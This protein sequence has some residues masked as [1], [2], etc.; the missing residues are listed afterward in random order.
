MLFVNTII[1]FLVKN[2]LLKNINF[3]HKRNLTGY[4][5]G[6]ER[7]VFKQHLLKNKASKLKRLYIH[8]ADSNVIKETKNL[9]N[10]KSDDTMRKIRSEAVTFFDRHKDDFIDILLMQR[11]HPEY[12]QEVSSPLSVKLYSREQVHLAETQKISNE[13]PILYFDATGSIVRSPSF[14]KDLKRVYLYSGVIWIEQTKRI[15]SLFDMISSKHFSATIFKFLY[16]FK[17]YSIQLNAWP[18]FGAVVTDFSFASIH[19]VIRSFNDM[20]LLAYLKQCYSICC[21]SSTSNNVGFVS[22]HLCCAHFMKMVSKDAR[23]IICHDA[24]EN[25]V[26]DLI[27]RCMTLTFKV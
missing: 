18:L 23:K 14:L 16:D 27:A 7:A 1:S 2:L 11:D 25:I 24:R 13:L 5:K 10:I 21:N 4:V 20:S 26:K 12:I 9:Q 22:L 15:V 8:E 6:I 3:S 19:A 17:C